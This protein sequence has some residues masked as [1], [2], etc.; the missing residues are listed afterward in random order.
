MHGLA[1]WAALS[2]WTS[3]VVGTYPQKDRVRPIDR[4]REQNQQARVSDCR[5]IGSWLLDIGTAAAE[6]HCRDG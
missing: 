5:S 4:S 1:L 6:A 2:R 3:K